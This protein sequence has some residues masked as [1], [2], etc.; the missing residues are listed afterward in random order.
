MNLVALGILVVTDVVNICIQ[1]GT[2]AIYVFTQEH[3]LV[4]VLM[5]LMFMILSF[6]AITI[7]STKRYLE[8]KYKKKYEFAL[9]QCP[10]YAERRRGVPKLR[11]DLMKFWMMA[12]TS[13]PQFVMARSSAVTLAEAMV[14]S[15]FLQPRSLGFCNGES[16]YKWSTTLVIISQGAAIAIGTVAPA[17]RWFSAVSL[18]CPSRGAKKGLRDEL[19]VESYWYDCLSEKKERPLNLWMLNGRRSRKLAHDVNRWMLDVCI[20]TQHVLVLASKF[21]RFITVYFVSRILL[22]CLFL[23]FKCETVSNAESC[24]SSPSTRRFVLHLEGEEELVDYMVRSNRE[25]TEHLIQKGRKQQPVNFVELLEGTTSI[26]KG[27]EGIWDFDSDEV[28]SLA[29]GEPPNCWAL[30]LVTLTSIA[31]AIPNIN[32]CS[33]KKLVKAVNE[34]L[35]YVKKFEDVLDT[36]GELANSRKAAEVVWLGVDLYHKWL[37]VDLRKLSK[38]QKTTTQVLKEL[39]EIAKKEFTDSWQKNLIFCMKH[40]PSHWP[41]KTLAANSMYRISQTLLNRYECLDIGTEEFLLKDVERMVSDIVAG[42]FCNAAQVI[43]MKCLVTAVEVREA[44]VREAAMHLGR[45]EKI[46]EI[47]DRRCMPALSHHKVAKID[48]WREFYRTNRCISLTR[49]SSQCTTRDLIL[50]LE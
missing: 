16:D 24:S 17:S 27:F 33:L 10:S 31:V 22:C 36:E 42:C 8:L 45:T 18:R 34:A 20:A 50:N 43:G 47:V 15:Y 13:S 35:V 37:N 19:R 39:V 46:L 6:S 4:I 30:P 3:A 5:F 11:E 1:L 49:P 23:T 29:S 28:P 32:P 38:Q 40:K 21:L 12:H 44:S 41:I 9:K 48:E 14:R 2:G 7:P 25:A 26:S